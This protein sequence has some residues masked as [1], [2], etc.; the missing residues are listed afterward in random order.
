MTR[1][2]RT[3][4]VVDDAAD[5]Q[6]ADPASPPAP[7]VGRHVGILYL[8]QAQ[9]SGRP[10][11]ELDLALREAWNEEEACR[12]LDRA[13]G[14]AWYEPAERAFVLRLRGPAGA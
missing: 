3:V 14:G 5:V 1:Q 9:R 2:L 6:A 4:V 13:H 7:R 10:A 12:E 11:R 8:T